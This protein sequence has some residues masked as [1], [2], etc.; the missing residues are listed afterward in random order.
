MPGRD[1][2]LE[3]FETNPKHT[4]SIRNDKKCSVFEAKRIA[5]KEILKAELQSPEPDL[6]K[7]LLTLVE[8]VL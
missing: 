5:L 3:A 1:K 7:V 6:A 2:P 4:V 8:N